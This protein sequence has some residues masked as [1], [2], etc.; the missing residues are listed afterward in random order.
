MILHNSK[1]FKGNEIDRMV[2]EQLNTSNIWVYNIV[3]Y[4]LLFGI[5]SSIYQNVS[6]RK[7]SYNEC[8]STGKNLKSQFVSVCVRA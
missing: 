8:A 1:G 6:L 3:K 2:E 7:I 4:Y 5:L